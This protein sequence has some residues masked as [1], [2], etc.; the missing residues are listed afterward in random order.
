MKTHAEI[1]AATL[2]SVMPGGRS[3]GFLE[4]GHDIALYH[5]EKWDGSGYP[6]GLSGE[7]I[8]LSARVLA[9]ADV[10]DALTTVRPYKQAWPHEKAIDWIRQGAG[11][12]FDPHAV[13]VFLAREHEVDSIRTRL[14]DD[15]AQSASPE[16]ELLARAT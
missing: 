13:E 8:P 15:V 9:L 12:H 1:G 14:A 7:D 6:C 5:H 3:Q 2:K 4:M 10:Y 16:G 11:A